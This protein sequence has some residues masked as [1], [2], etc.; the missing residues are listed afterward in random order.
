MS[1]AINGGTPVRKK[2]M[3]WRKALGEHEVEQLLAVV[4]YYHE[5]EEDPPYS[6][7]FKDEFCHSFSQFM[8]GG[9]TNAVSSGTAALYVSLA[10]LQLPKGSE[11]IISPVTDSGSLTPIVLQDFIPVV[12]DSEPGSYNMG[13]RQCLER[14]SSQTAAIMLVH[15]AGE[16]VRDVEAIVRE[17]RNRGVLVIEDCSQATGGELDGKRVGA[18]GDIAAF[19]TMY[20]KNLAAG[21]SSGLVYT[22][23]KDLYQ[24]ALAHSDRGKPLWRSDL[25][26]RDPGY[27]DFP[28]LNF[29]TCEFS[30]AVGSASLQRLQDTID[31]RK[32]FLRAFLERL[33]REIRVCCPYTFHEGFS[34]FYFPIFVETDDITCSKDEF[35]AALQAEGIGVGVR[36]GCLINDWDWA[37]PFLK[38]D[39]VARN[40]IDARDQAFHLYVNEN[41]GEEEVDDIIRAILKVE[42]HYSVGTN[43]GSFKEKDRE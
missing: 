5:R 33:K 25:D 38:D 8:G 42:G 22:T 7:H 10:A 17:A 14:I 21:A 26:F 23:N 31:K 3:P 36:Y 18:F 34:P 41:Y 32:I 39:F 4:K 19:S 13:L 12:A 35:A 1:L 24:R 43:T 20:R 28:A 30:C 40:A 9:Y 16:P 27:A 37:K 2:K 15:A 11:V 6:G 29:N